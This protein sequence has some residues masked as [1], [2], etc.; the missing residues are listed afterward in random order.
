MYLMGV[1]T[2]A[3]SYY[4][5]RY[6][7][8]LQLPILAVSFALIAFHVNISLPISLQLAAQK[9]G[10]LRAK[11]LR[12]DFLGSLTLVSAVACLLVAV[13]LNVVEET[14]ASDPLVY[15]L[16]TA[17]AISLVLFIG[18]EAKVA[19]EPILPMR[20]LTSRTPVATAIVNFAMSIV[21]Y[22]V[23]YNIPLYFEAVR[24]Q[25]AS[26]AGLH[27]LPNSAS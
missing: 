13:T 2:H 4:S 20:L 17:S 1:Y 26:Q 5:R 11:I 12:I 23:L 7:F 21:A 9:S 22:S 18:V 8:L 14:P 10:T 16:F 27:L 3:G 24:L 19:K 25:T 6:A 15:G